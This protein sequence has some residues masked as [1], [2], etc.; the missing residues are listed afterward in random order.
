M[1]DYWFDFHDN[2]EAVRIA[3]EILE[4][5]HERFPVFT[6]SDGGTFTF[7][8]KYAVDQASLVCAGR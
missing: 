7:Y 3:R 8:D 5:A 4:E 6:T 1:T 2:D